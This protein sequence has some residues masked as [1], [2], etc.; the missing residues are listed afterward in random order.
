MPSFGLH[1]RYETSGWN[2]GTS[3]RV[4]VDAPPIFGSKSFK[5]ALVKE[6]FPS[7]VEK[8]IVLPSSTHAFADCFGRALV[9]RAVNFTTLRTLN[10]LLRDVGLSGLDIQYI[11]GLF[12]LLSFGETRDAEV[13]L[14]KADVW[15]EWFE[16]LK[17]WSG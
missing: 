13:F 8:V 11:G 14:D 7:Q 3:N 10:V 2:Q 16:T 4:E 15:K 9:G 6:C 5:E 12:V 17:L 1:G